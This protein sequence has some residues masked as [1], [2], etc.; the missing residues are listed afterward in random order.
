MMRLSIQSDID[1][2]ISQ[3][4]T[5]CAPGQ[6]AFAV[7]R[8]LTQTAKDVQAEVRANMPGRF[9]LRRNWI[10]Q[11]IMVKFATKANLEAIVYSRDDFM[12]AQE[13]GGT[14]DPRGNYLAIP[15]S[16]VRRTPKDVIRR[17][18]RPR[19][20]GDKA[21]VVEVNGNKFLALKRPRR[22]AN[23]NMLRFMYLLVDRAQI[24]QRLKLN[25]DGRRVAAANFQQNLL[26]AIEF[27]MR[28]RR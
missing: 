12:R 23:G 28:T 9:T 1:N 6:L 3:M 21:E 14:K 2:A 27:A 10:V 17:A 8:A 15:T 4:Q 22:G 11:G 16:L 19:A 5:I 24:D 13:Y 26:D 25:D 20:L 7:S 18:D